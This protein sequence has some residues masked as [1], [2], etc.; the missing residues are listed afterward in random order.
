M[1]GLFKNCQQQQQQQKVHYTNQNL[2]NP[3]KP[4][5]IHTDFFALKWMQRMCTIVLIVTFVNE[6]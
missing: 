2:S 4:R 5:I 3:L 1:I 6:I